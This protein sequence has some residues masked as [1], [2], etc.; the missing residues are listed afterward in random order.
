MWGEA[1]S[2]LE[3]ADRLHRQLMG[4][5]PGGATWEP[6]ADVIETA[7]ELVV[8]VAL[9]GVS[10]ADVAIGIESDA[11]T[12]SALRS[13]PDCRADSRIHRIEIPYGRFERRIAVP[14]A[15]GVLELAGRSL[16]DGCLT[17]RFTKK[18]AA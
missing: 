5:S 4:P 15:Q 7:D 18:E 6:P 1:L 13:F 11:I 2:L 10:P 12:V 8:H 17:L 3:Q 16:Q 14:M 9:P